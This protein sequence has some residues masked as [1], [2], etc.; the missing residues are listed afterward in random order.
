MEWGCSASGLL[1]KQDIDYSVKPLLF[2]V[3]VS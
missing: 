1:H 3:S 2:G